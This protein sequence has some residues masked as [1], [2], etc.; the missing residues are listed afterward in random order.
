MKLLRKSSENEMLI[1]F[2]RAEYSSERFSALIKTE[3]N[4]LGYD[5]KI[6]LSADINNS[7]ENAQRKKLMGEFRGYAINQELFENFPPV[8]DWSIYSFNT[9]D[10]EKIRYIDY[11]YWNELSDG[12]HSPLT[13][14]KTIHNGKTVFG[15]SNDDFLKAAEFIKGGGAFHKMF[16][17]T[18][19]FE[20]F[21]IVEGHLRMTAYALAPDY[22]NGIEV[23]VGKCGSQELQKWI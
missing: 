6:I 13:A 11:D 10:L 20:R 2:L 4:K 12:T 5:E 22:F 23:I 3:L 18:S 16:F 1:E 14:A 15:E 21:V 8:T 19:D 7:V 17:L 9:E